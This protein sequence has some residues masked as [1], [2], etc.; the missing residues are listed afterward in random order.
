MN[1]NDQIL[2]NKEFNF[3]KQLMYNLAVAIC[4]MLGLVLIL[5]YGFKFGLY[6]VLSDSQA[7]TFVKGDLVVTKPEK[8]Y[9]IGDILKFTDLDGSPV[10]HRLIAIMGDGTEKYYFCHGDNVQTVI[11]A[12]GSKILS[13]EEDSEFLQSL[14]DEGKTLNQLQTDK[15]LVNT[16]TFQI[17]EP[18]R[19]QGRVIAHVDNW[20]GYIDFAKEHYMLFVALIAGVWCVCTVVENEI[21]IKKAK[22][23][24]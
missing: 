7:P 3:F 24:E 1:Y 16:G 13:W 15:F 20:G 22:R 21:Y 19:V 23:L 5:V 8:E 6:N 2:E 11:P 10:T 9:E 18:S 14:I 17:V 4:V 12:K